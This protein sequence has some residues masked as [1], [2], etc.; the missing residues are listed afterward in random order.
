MILADGTDVSYL[1]EGD[2]SAGLSTQTSRGLEPEDDRVGHV[3]VASDLDLDQPQID[4]KLFDLNVDRGP[5]L[6][7]QRRGNLVRDLGRGL[8]RQFDGVLDNVL[9]L[10]TNTR[11]VVFGASRSDDRCEVGAKVGRELGLDLKVDLAPDRAFDGRAQ[12][13]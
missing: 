6:G 10:C 1:F 2:V 12:S 7:C 9:A 13:C 5:D 4:R 11:R 8:Y 3:H